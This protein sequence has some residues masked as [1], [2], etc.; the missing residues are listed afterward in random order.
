MT[1]KEIGIRNYKMYLSYVYYTERV[2]D[3]NLTEKILSQAKLHCDQA[4]LPIIEEYEKEFMK[5]ME[6]RIK[7][8]I[9]N[10]IGEDMAPKNQ[11]GKVKREDAFPEERNNNGPALRQRLKFADEESKF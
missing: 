4:S 2:R 3:F 9:V 6:S 10:V 1:S 7:R 5:R 8:D 11:F